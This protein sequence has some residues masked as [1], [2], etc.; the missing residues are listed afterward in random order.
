MNNTIEVRIWSEG[1][2][3]LEREAISVET[4]GSQIEIIGEDGEQTFEQEEWDEL[5][6]QD[7]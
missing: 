4:D 6:V 7:V 2:R 3:V 5:T 1:T